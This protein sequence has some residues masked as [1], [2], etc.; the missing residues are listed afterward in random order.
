MSEETSEELAE[1][2]TEKAEERTEKA[3]Q[4]TAMA[5]DRTLLANERTF[6]GW[7]RTSLACIGV[8]LGFQA[9]FR[10]VQPVWVAKLIATL[11]ISLAIY[12]IWQA[13]SRAS[14]L[15]DTKSGNSV[16]LMRENNFLI[17]AIAISIAAAMLIG[18]IWFLV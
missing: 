17:L 1:E 4:R 11:I 15:G 14:A 7:S 6:A 12:I 9:I 13:E 5:E 3:E 8:G 16:K 18:A 2:R 10:T